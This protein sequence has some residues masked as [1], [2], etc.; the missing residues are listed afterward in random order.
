MR[1]RSSVPEGQGKRIRRHHHRLVGPRRPRQRPFRRRILQVGAPGAQAG[2]RDLLAGRVRVA[3]LAA[4]QKHD[5][6]VPQCLR[7]RAVCLLHHPDVPV[8][9]DRLPVVR[10]GRRHHLPRAL[11]QRHA[12]AARRIPVLFVVHAQSFIHSARVCQEE[13]LHHSPS[14]CLPVR[15]THKE[16]VDLWHAKWRRRGEG[17][18]E[19]E[20]GEKRIKGFGLRFWLWHDGV[21]GASVYC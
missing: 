3:S 1:R 7:K 4:H 14:P 2:R 16:G 11:A 9:A 19:N 15:E 13:A 5:G 21:K 12:G 17:V 18:A 8:G 6:H 10:Q 20:N